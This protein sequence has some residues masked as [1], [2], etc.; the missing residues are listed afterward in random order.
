MHSKRNYQQNDNSSYG[1][2]E[3]ICKW[4]NWQKVNIQNLWTAHTTQY[5]KIYKQPSQKMQGPE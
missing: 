4:C 5:Q 2:G 3:N 1:I